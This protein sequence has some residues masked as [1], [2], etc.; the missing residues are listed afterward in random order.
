MAIIAIIPKGKE[1]TAARFCEDQMHVTIEFGNI[2]GQM[3]V[4]P[5]FND[6]AAADAFLV[7]FLPDLLD[8]LD[9]PVEIV[10]R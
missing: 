1:E 2:D 8:E 10:K 3:T 6:G 4:Q 7:D 9:A 5:L